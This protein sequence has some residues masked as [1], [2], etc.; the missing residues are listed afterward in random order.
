MKNT[1][2]KPAGVN[3]GK[4][5]ANQSLADPRNEQNAAHTSGFS[6]PSLES[7]F[8]TPI[9]DIDALLLLATA[10]SAKRRPATL[11]EI[12]A[13]ID[14]LHGN[15]PAEPKLSEALARLAVNG[16]L[17][18]LDGGIALTPAAQKIVEGLPR[19][20]DSAERLFIIKDRLS[21]YNVRGQHAPILLAVE[22]LKEALLAHR[23]A[24]EG[25][26][27]NLLVPKPKPAEEIKRPGQRQRKP[28]PARRRKD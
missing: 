7:I 12:M 8:M 22:Q 10:L 27:K 19:K 28:A 20:A 11:V 1:S 9:H 16:L 17:V 14:L 21:D 6:T 18:E 4:A 5:I 3:F 25:A 24:G 15:I 26:A 2:G 23:A 13:A